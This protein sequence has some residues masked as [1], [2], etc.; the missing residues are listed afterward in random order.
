MTIDYSQMDPNMMMGGG[1]YGMPMP[2]D[3]SL[4]DSQQAPPQNSQPQTE[5]H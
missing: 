4:N 5:Q 3:M 2:M 1:Q